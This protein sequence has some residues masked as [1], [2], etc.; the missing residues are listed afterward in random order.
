M[1]INIYINNIYIYVCYIHIHVCLDRYT[2]TYIFLHTYIY[3]YIYICIYAH[4]YVYT[5]QAS[6]NKYQLETF[7]RV[8][9]LNIPAKVFLQ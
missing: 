3:I 7:P 1:Y 6:L 5:R 9:D 2:S 8:L 4:I